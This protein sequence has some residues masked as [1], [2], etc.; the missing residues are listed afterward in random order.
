M[1][2][3]PDF[4]PG[5]PEGCKGKIDLLFV[6]ARNGTMLTEQQQLLAS[7]P[8]FIKTIEET[9]A[10][11]DT[12]TIVA[13]PDGLWSG[14]FCESFNQCGKNGNCGPN[15]MEYQC[16]SDYMVEPCD[17][18]L[19]AG[20]LYNAGPFATNHICE[21]Y[22]GRRYIIPGQPNLAEAFTCI[23]KIGVTSP[24]SPLGDAL[25]AAVSDK[26]NGAG[27]CNEGFLRKDALLVVTLITDHEDEDSKTSPAAWYDAVVAAK[28][29]DP[30]AVVALA[31]T[32]Q[33]FVDEWLPN[34]TY[35]DLG[36]P[37][38]FEDLIEMF[39]YHAEGDPCAATYAPFFADAVSLVAEACDSYIPQ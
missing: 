31:I 7:L 32:P 26:I 1:G 33:P 18:T 21:L 34:C 30:N 12:H 27:G 28:G 19:G 38:K 17:I 8:G 35:N 22:G 3:Q 4:G 11:F 13:N 36:Y 16:Y 39:P 14:E 2:V 29:G 10:D 37:L 25:V 23:A 20:L 5:L 9:F 6:I 24:I 15:A